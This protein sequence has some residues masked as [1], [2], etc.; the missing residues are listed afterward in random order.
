M[1]SINTRAFDHAF[2][3]VLKGQQATRH[4]GAKARLNALF[5]DLKRADPRHDPDETVDLIWSIWCDHPER[6]ATDRLFAAAEAMA[7]GARDLAR[8]M[9][10][11]LVE[12]HPDWAEAWNKRATLAFFEKRDG[13]SINDIA[14]TLEL[15]P[16]HFGAILGFAQICL[17]HRRLREAKAAFEIALGMNPHMDELRPLIQDLSTNRSSLH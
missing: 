12:A 17:R 15:E 11:A 9:L 7:S 5:N 8:P 2:Q 6:Q 1:R 16:R 3:L 14:R 4:R 13:D 10:D